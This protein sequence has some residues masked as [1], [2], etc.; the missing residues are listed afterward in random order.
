MEYDFIKG[1]RFEVKNKEAITLIDCGY[2]GGW[3]KI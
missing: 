3:I 2:E 1:G